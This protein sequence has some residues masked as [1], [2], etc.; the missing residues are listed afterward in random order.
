MLFPLKFRL[1]LLYFL[2]QKKLGIVD[3]S[4]VFALKSM[5]KMI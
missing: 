5:A 3:H 2:M 4:K 1:V